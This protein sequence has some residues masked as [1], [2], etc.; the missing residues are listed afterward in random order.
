[1]SRLI[2]QFVRIETVAVRP[3]GELQPRWRDP[4]VVREAGMGEPDGDRS[5]LR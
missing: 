3:A 4:P 5:P 1:M 2:P